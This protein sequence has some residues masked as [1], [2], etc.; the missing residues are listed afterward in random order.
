MRRIGFLISP[1]VVFAC[2]IFARQSGAQET[3]DRERT[4]ARALE[5][6]DH[7]KTQDEFRHAASEFESMLAGGYMNGGVLYNLG[8]AYFGAHD[9]GKAIAAYRKAKL[10][11]PRDLLLDAILREAT[12]LAP[13]RLAEPAPPWWTH[14]LFWSSWLSYPEKIYAACGVWV[15]GAFLVL[16]GVRFRSKRAYWFSGAAV[17]AAVLLSVDAGIAY[18]D[19]FHPRHA[20]VIGETVAR[21]GNSM[22]YQPAFDQS[23]KE[24]AEFTIIERR[25][26]WVLGR[27]EGAG[28]GWVAQSAI[29][30]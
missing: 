19:V 30:E 17:I 1:V 26:D 10:Y 23:L 9:Y 2:F 22:D 5:L 3:V 16:A 14:A 28:D 21:K 20:V 18:D 25:G 7:A 12:T 27:F 29:V 4:F 8:N 13:G 24:G 6:L 11:R 15:L